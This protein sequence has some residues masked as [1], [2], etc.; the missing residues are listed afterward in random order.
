MKKR[1]HE[2]VERLARILEADA[3]KD[4]I[5]SVSK[6]HGVSG[7]YSGKLIKDVRSGKFDQVETDLD[8]IS[9]LVTNECDRLTVNELEPFEIFSA[10]PESI[11]IILYNN[12]DISKTMVIVIE[13]PMIDDQELFELEIEKRILKK[14]LKDLRWG[15]AGRKFNEVE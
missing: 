3:R 7:P 5:L 15:L 8:E 10:Y 12:N 13:K 1:T 6:K 14:I 11:E 2:E 4:S 9:E